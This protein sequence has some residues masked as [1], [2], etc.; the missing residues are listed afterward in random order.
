[1]TDIELNYARCFGTAAGKQVLEHLRN[2]TIVSNPGTG[3]EESK[4][5]Q[6][7]KGLIFGLEFDDSFADAVEFYTDADCAEY[8]DPYADTASDLTIYVKWTNT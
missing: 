3:K 4:R 2:I 5:I 8:Y 1:M 6:V 7:P